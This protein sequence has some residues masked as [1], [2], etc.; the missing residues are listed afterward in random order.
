MYAATFTFLT[1]TSYS[2]AKSCKDRYLSNKT[3]QQIVY[4]KLSFC[5]RAVVCFFFLVNKSVLRRHILVECKCCSFLLIFAHITRSSMVLSVNCAKKWIFL[6]NRTNISKNLGT[7][8]FFQNTTAVLYF[9]A[10]SERINSSQ[11]MS[12][13]YMLYTRYVFYICSACSSSCTSLLRI[14]MQQKL[15]ILRT[16]NQDFE[17]IRQTLSNLNLVRVRHAF[18]ASVK[19]CTSLYGICIFRWSPAITESRK[20]LSF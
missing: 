14:Q 19:K 5:D 10:V 3:T 18:S 15:S 12:Y 11:V 9:Y 17:P 6:Y 7:A 13:T 4:V 8:N 16:Q 20:M 1:T 2:Q